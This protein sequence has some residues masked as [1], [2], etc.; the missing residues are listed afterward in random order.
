MGATTAAPGD[1]AVL[2]VRAA[3]LALRMAIAACFGGTCW[4]SLWS[5][6][7]LGM[8]HPTDV[9][10]GAVNGVACGMIAWMYLRPQFAE[11]PY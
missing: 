8:H 11:A 1:G 7:Y 10:W 3:E 4:C 9:A 2:L 6:V 5:R